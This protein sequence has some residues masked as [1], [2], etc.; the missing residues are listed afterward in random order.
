MTMQYKNEG[1]KSL[2]AP[3]MYSFIKKEDG[4]VYIIDNLGFPCT[5]EE[6]E[7]LIKGL[8]QHLNKKR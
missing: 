1:E 7:E 8:Q 6:I 3:L 5:D 2:L 4:T